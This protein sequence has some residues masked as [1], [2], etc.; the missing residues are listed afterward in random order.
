MDLK[1][2][3]YLKRYNQKEL[4]E[5]KSQARKNKSERSELVK[6]IYEEHYCYW[7]SKSNLDAFKYTYKEKD[8]TPEN[9]AKFKKSKAYYPKMQIV[10][11][12]MKIAHIPTKDLYYLVSVAKDMKNRKQNFNKWLFWSMKTQTDTPVNKGKS[13]VIPLNHTTNSS[14]TSSN[15]VK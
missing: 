14:V 15:M 10:R 12:C 1:L 2:E 7:N 6:E 13:E 9:Q 5:V 4:D 8:R 3:E 11:F